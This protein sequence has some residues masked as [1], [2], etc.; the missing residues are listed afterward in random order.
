MIEA[1]VAMMSNSIV[2]ELCMNF[3]L[4]NS[5]TFLKIINDT[6]WGKKNHCQTSSD[7]L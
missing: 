4:V 1:L 3:V 2:M 7:D 5:E 6:I